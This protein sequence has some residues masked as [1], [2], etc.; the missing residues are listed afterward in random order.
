M[1]L[2]QEPKRIF[3]LLISILLLIPNYNNAQ[4]ALLVDFGTNAS[5]NSFGLDGWNTLLLDDD[6]TYSSEG[7][8]GVTLQTNLDNFSDYMGVSGTSRQFSLGER[9]VV[10]WYNIS[11]EIIYFTSR[12]SFT[13]N[14]NPSEMSEGH[15][16]T[17]RSFEDYRITYTEI[18]PH[19]T[20]KTV[21]NITDEGVHKTDSVYSLVN[22]NLSI[23]WF[24]SFMK[25][26]LV[27]DKIELW[28]DADISP[29]CT[30]EA[31]S[32]VNV[33]PFEVNLEWNY[34]CDD[35][36]PVEY[37][38]YR[39]DE[40]EG[41]SREMNFTAYYL[42]QSTE[43]SFSVTALDKAGNESEHSE[44]ITVST[45][46]F[47]TSADVINPSGFEYLG[48]I[49]LPE[50]FAYGADG[51]AYNSNGD[52]GQSGNGSAD[53]YP[54][55]FFVTDI[56]QPDRGFVGEITIPEPV[57]T[58]TKNIEELNQAVILQTPVD[59]RP[60][61]VNNW[62]YVDVW[63]TGLEYVETE[64]RLY[65]SW[66]IYYDVI[67]DKTASLSCIDANNL[68]GGEKY[69]AWFWGSSDESDIPND[70]YLNDY[71]FQV[72]QSWADENLNGQSLINGRYREGGLSGLGPT[73]YSTSPAG[74][75]N[76]PDANTETDFS[77]LLQ[78]GPVEES[79]NYN[80][81]NSLN[82]YNH[83]DW[84]KGAD[85]ISIDEQNAVVVIG[86]KGL[87]HNYYGYNGERMRHDWVIADLP[88][89]EFAET[90]PNGKGWKAYNTA[91][92]IIFYDPADLAA[93]AVGTMESYDPQ[94]YAALR[95]DKNIFFGSD[96]QISS[97]AY[98]QYNNILYIAE[99]VQ[100]AFG[101]IVIHAWKINYIETDVETT[102]QKQFDFVLEQNYPNP[103][104]PTTTIK[105]TIPKVETPYMASLHTKLIVYNSLGQ[106]VATLV[107][108]QKTPGVYEV[109][110]DARSFSS[111]V[112][113]YKLTSGSFSEARKLLLLK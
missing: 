83:A 109:Q 59:I 85:W 80:F 110:F 67:F 33:S 47:T 97:A 81:P 48:V 20:A 8:G 38:I 1:S 57:T 96:A 43:Y 102:I 54:G 45:P 113:F 64:N 30:P 28:N 91:P 13:D 15:W 44:S 55:S 58:S 93:V 22:V 51:L 106:E 3:F 17:M 35:L 71:L 39:D 26:Y 112:Y 73:F 46:T 72:P 94:P 107:N 14:D 19:D 92:M 29:P 101:N 79:D 65:S 31:L 5:S 4:K 49:G 56:N 61:N 18:L 12:I 77:T 37:I 89:P 24:D 69:G 98:D 78:Y 36:D 23:E 104:N 60:E 111:G 70:P 40:I 52:G 75:N 25:Q 27:C 82:D 41:Y 53:S 74:N 9:I 66:A 99:F 21:F 32:A 68:A 6:M 95:L 16:Y 108:E 86:N 88:Y 84:W 34:P 10:T 62:E 90:D 42:N 105:F 63:L 76:P 7:P 11:D 87:G 50:D 100:E 2:L 103:F